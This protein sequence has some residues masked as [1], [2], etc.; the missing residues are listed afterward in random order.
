MKTTQINNLLALTLCAVG[1]V[2]A[3]PT[4]EESVYPEVIPGYGLPSLASLNL[5]SA[6]L[7]QRVPSPG[8]RTLFLNVTQVLTSA[9]FNS[10]IVAGL[11]RRFNLVCNQVAQCSLSDASACANFINALGHQACNVPN[12]FLTSNTFCTA[13]GCKWYGTNWKT[14]GGAVS[15]FWCIPST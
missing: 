2:N 6:E 12:S 11:E 9:I 7:Y 4:A 3:L 10:D 14:G 15:S 8:K 1:L 13:G 5:T